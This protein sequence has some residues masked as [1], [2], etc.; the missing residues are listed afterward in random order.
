MR[1]DLRLHGRLED[2]R[3]C[4]ADMSVYVKDESEKQKAVEEASKTAAWLV[5]EPGWPDVPNDAKITVEHVENLAEKLQ[6][7]EP[8]PGSFPAFL[9]KLGIPLGA[10]ELIFPMSPDE[11]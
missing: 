11:K 7:Q 2:G 9:K 10:G 5:N 6:P 1:L 8:L 3:K 4:S